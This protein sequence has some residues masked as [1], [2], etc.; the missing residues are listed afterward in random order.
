[1]PCI[2]L[3]TTKHSLHFIHMIE[4][5][6]HSWVGSEPKLIWDHINVAK[7]NFPN[8]THVQVHTTYIS[9]I[10]KKY[11][12]KSCRNITV[13][14]W[15]DLHDH[16]KSDKVTKFHYSCSVF[17]SYSVTTLVLAWTSRACWRIPGSKNAPKTCLLPQVT[18]WWSQWGLANIVILS[19]N[20]FIWILYKVRC[21]DQDLL[22]ERYFV[23]PFNQ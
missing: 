12:K 5:W 21:F 2:T 6:K 9:F 18:E 8:I 11:L 23:F 1:M 14:F 16:V 15:Q 13:S 7:G 20:K 22:Q 3:I 10:I 17:P 4:V 19:S